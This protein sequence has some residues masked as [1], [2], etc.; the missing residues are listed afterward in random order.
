MYVNASWADD[1]LTRIS[2]SVILTYLGDHL[3]DRSSKLQ[4]II[5]HNTSEAEYVSAGSST[6]MI[7]WFRTL[8]ENLDE[9]HH[10]PTELHEDNM[11]HLSLARDTSDCVIVICARK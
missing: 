4:S 5:T 7:V 10:W 8:L 6:R 11:A 9:E 2:T 1:L 3:L